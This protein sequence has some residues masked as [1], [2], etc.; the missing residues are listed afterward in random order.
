MAAHKPGPLGRRRLR[1]PI[2]PQYEA[3]E[4]GAACLGSV[5]AHFGRWVSQEELRDTCAVSRDGSTAA[6]IFRAAKQYGLEVEAWTKEPDQLKDLE[7]PSILFWEF[8]HFVVLEGFG[9]GVYY[10]ND[11]A[12]GRRTLDEQEFSESFT[13]VVMVM[14]PGPD[15]QPGGERR[16]VMRK[17]RPWLSGVKRPLGFVAACGLLLALPGL[18]LPVLLTLFVNEVL[19]AQEDSWAGPVALAAGLAAALTFVLTWLQQKNLRR[20]AIR[21]SAT[22]GEQMLSRLFRLPAQFFTHRYAGDLTTRVQL[23]ETTS[24]QVSTQFT[25]LMI[26]LVM[27]VAFLALMIVYDPVLAAVVLGLGLANVA[28]TR[29]VSRVRNDENQQVQRELALLA[30]VSSAGLRN[31]EALR[32][33][34]T[35]DDFF[36]RWSGHQAREL[37]A[38]QKF[39]EL[40]YV[41]AALPGLILLL[42][43]VAVFGVGGWRVM[44][45]DMTIGALMGF[46]L[47]ANGF[48][49]PIGRF[50]RYADAFQV[51][52]SNL[53]R[54]HDVTAAPEDPVFAAPR[55]SQQGLRGPDRAATLHGRLRLDGRMELRNVTFGYRPN[56]APLIEEFSL[57]VAA[58]QRV[59]VIGPTG[60]GKSTLLKLVAGGYTPWSGEIQ[61]DGVPIG[62]VPREVLTSS[63]A[64]VDQH[65]YLFSG[66]VRDNLTMWNPAVSDHRMVAA[67]R[68]ALIHD[69]I[70]SRPGGY[71]AS[72]DEAGM[73]FSHGQRQR[74]EIARALAANPSVMLLDEATSRLDAVTELGIDDALR[75]R[76]CTCLIVA[77]RL[78]TI[79]D[80]DQIVVLDGGRAV[81]RGTHDE[82]LADRQGMYFRLI[83][84][85]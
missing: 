11:P 60:S 27:S 79:R 65:I 61:F 45:D 14:Q 48:L 1:T 82:L 24:S 3:T 62:E 78:S 9:N 38:R 58:G 69:E 49:Q 15:F 71:S 40:G 67:A 5:L 8:N 2:F 64:V 76:G 53:Q 70:M 18:L 10:L 17:V 30:G 80:C 73:N 74:M 63:V 6:D 28:V 39:A 44:S 84:A 85:E 42:N 56:H 20:L 77:H 47:L 75:R 16:G 25:G 26:E 72:V 32:S 43:A 51:M 57:T 33:T 50:A 54:I 83:Q 41:T 12:V 21:L 66:T 22:Q 34:A 68:D 59:A 46:Y 55:R 35:E 36:A 23:V 81:Q 29:V 37:T 7:L 31:I 13:G 52:E 4:C 19:F